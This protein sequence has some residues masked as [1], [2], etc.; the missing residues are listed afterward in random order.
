MNRLLTSFLLSATPVLAQAGER[1][2]LP[3][4]DLVSATT[5]ACRHVFPL[6]L[7]EGGKEAAPASMFGENA[8]LGAL[9]PR[10]HLPAYYSPGALTEAVVL[11]AALDAGQVQAEGGALLVDRA[12]ADKAGAAL[13]TLRKQLTPPV[14]VDLMLEQLDP[15]DKARGVLVGREVTLNGET[16]ILSELHDRAA[17]VDFEVEIAQAASIACPVTSTMHFGASAA[18]RCRVLPTGEAAIVEAAVR[19]LDP[20]ETPPIDPVHPGFGPIDRVALVGTEAGF[21]LRVKQDEEAQQVWSGV[22]G[23]R[24]RLRVRARWAATPADIKAAV[25]QSPFLHSDV[26][27][28][29]LRRTVEDDAQEEKGE[30]EEPDG[31]RNV[32]AGLLSVTG[33]AP[34]LQAVD[35]ESGLGVL[36]DVTPAM[37]Q[38]RDALVKGLDRMNAGAEIELRLLDMANGQSP[39]EEG[40]LP[41]GARE[42]A[43]VQ[44]RLVRGR[45][46]C[47]TGYKERS[48]L[49]GWGCEVA[50]SARIPD[51]HIRRVREGWSVNL[52][53]GTEGRVTIESEVRRIEAIEASNV[54]LDVVQNMPPQEVNVPN[55]PPAKGAAVSLPQDVVSIEKPR[56]SSQLLSTTMALGAN[57]TASIRRGAARL[58]GADRD[59]LLVLRAK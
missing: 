58:F 7:P 14:T 20:V 32:V 21:A 56:I 43:R 23:R 9:P 57:G 59:L 42:I 37:P 8:L 2:S 24:W 41:V 54:P 16:R 31:P 33:Q 6:T 53:L 11:L 5:L 27:G 28:F 26:L 1:V 47:F 19:V 18:F 4:H 39:T 52:L 46:V 25:L 15:N 30:A 17:L 34:Q 36:V 35:A 49:A 44:G 51:P 29:R 50:Q 12:A 40:G 48:Y 38:I 10:V 55:Q 3:I 22:D 13:E 45:F